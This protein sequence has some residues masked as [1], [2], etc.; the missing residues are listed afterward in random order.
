MSY[1]DRKQEKKK[2]EDKEQEEEK[3]RKGRGR[4]DAAISATRVIKKHTKRSKEAA[5]SPTPVLGSRKSSR[6]P[7]H[8]AL[9]PSG[10]D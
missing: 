8:A 5:L 2:E 4:R 9:L 3:K 6:C 1:R 10:T 7:F